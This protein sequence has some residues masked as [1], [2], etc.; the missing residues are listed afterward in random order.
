M[1]ALP[2]P[3]ELSLPANEGDYERKSGSAQDGEIVRLIP[4]GDM[5]P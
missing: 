5:S 3:L 4:D 1:Q 2:A